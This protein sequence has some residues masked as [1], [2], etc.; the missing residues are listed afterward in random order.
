MAKKPK[1]STL[2]NKADKYWAFR[3]KEL[4]EFQCAV[5]GKIDGSLNVKGNKTYLNAHHVDG[6][7]NYRLRYDKLNGIA[8]CTGCHDLNK[9]SAEQSPI[10]F[11][12]WLLEKRPGL[13]DYILK[14]RE[15]EV[16]ITIEWYQDIIEECMN[17]FIL[18]DDEQ[19]A[20]NF[21]ESFPMRLP[22]ADYQA[23][24]QGSAVWKEIQKKLALRDSR[25]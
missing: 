3:I 8:L 22:D 13:I 20:V 21:P 18:S 14:V 7:N 6:R 24:L 25:R 4:H 12:Q 17:P 19:V 2:R 9:N 11:Y 16:K 10:W 5:C 15:E 23:C 1:R